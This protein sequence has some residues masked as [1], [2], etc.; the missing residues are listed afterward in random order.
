MIARHQKHLVHGCVLHGTSR[1]PHIQ[2]K[3]QEHIAADFA[4]DQM[5]TFGHTL[6]GSGWLLYYM[7]MYGDSSPNTGVPRRAQLLGCALSS[8]PSAASWEPGSSTEPRIASR[9]TSNLQLLADIC[10]GKANPV[11]LRFAWCKHVG[12]IR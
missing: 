7:Q 11:A 1:L 10:A 2:C 8:S 4:K 6:K 9:S 5:H 3:Q 12:S